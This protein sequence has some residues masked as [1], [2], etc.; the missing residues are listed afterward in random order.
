MQVDKHT[1]TS[2][3]PSEYTEPDS[4]LLGTI[5]YV[6]CASGPLPRLFCGSL[7][8]MNLLTP[9][10]RCDGRCSNI[11]NIRMGC[12]WGTL[13]SKLWWHFPAIFNKCKNAEVA[14]K[15]NLTLAGLCFW[16][17]LLSYSSYRKCWGLGCFP[18]LPH[19]SQYSRSVNH[20]PNYNS[21]KC[22][23]RITQRLNNT[24]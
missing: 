3:K 1:Q 23:F 19:Q 15:S 2:D 18:L 16:C 14:D 5:I 20:S 12:G 24:H 17:P 13:S 4:I 21:R 10:N 22:F 6:A 11:L 8:I 9:V 7:I